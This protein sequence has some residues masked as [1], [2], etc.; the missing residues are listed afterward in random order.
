MS[1]EIAGNTEHPQP[2]EY[3]KVSTDLRERIKWAIA[4]RPIGP[5]LFSRLAGTKPLVKKGILETRKDFF[6]YATTTPSPDGDIQSVVITTLWNKSGIKKEPDA[7]IEFTENGVA[8]VAQEKETTPD[9][10]V[11]TTL[12]RKSVDPT[13]AMAEVEYPNIIGAW[14]EWNRS[15]ASMWRKKK[16]LIKG[17]N[18]VGQD[19]L[20]VSVI[21]DKQ[22]S[23]KSA[24]L[25]CPDQPAI[26]LLNEF[27][28][29]EEVEK[30][31][32]K[33][34]EPPEFDLLETFNG[35]KLQAESGKYF[36]LDFG[37]LSILVYP[38]IFVPTEKQA[39]EM[40]IPEEAP[41]PFMLRFRPIH[42]KGANQYGGQYPNILATLKIYP[43]L[44]PP[45]EEIARRGFVGKEDIV[46]QMHFFGFNMDDQTAELG[47]L[48]ARAN[49]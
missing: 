20:R 5:P 17:K 4:E 13:G 27:P 35:R 18:R 45:L 8:I 33:K 32:I 15:T 26:D 48:L 21:Y 2:S 41:F 42:K 11:I 38:G 10:L 36:T 6:Q 39:S 43:K 19:A 34:N 16:E 46:S 40:R 14:N 28:S 23:L 31:R 9:G 29:S 3:I 7:H 49:Q 30:I 22:G 44:Y 47:S 1:N 37:E 25:T 24:F 12:I